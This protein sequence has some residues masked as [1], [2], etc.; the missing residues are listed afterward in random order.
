MTE[1]RMNVRVRAIQRVCDTRKVELR[2]ALRLGF[3]HLGTNGGDHV[4]RDPEGRLFCVDL[5]TGR[6]VQCAGYAPKITKW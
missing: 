4:V 1:A 6:V 5:V 2:D 3:K